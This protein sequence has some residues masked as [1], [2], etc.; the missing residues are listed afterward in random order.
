MNPQGGGGSPPPGVDYALKSR[1]IPNQVMWPLTFVSRDICTFGSGDP[2]HL[3]HVT[4]D[5]L[6]SP[7]LRPNLSHRG[8]EAHLSFHVSRGG[9]ET[10]ELQGPGDTETAH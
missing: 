3:S 5:R 9:G 4:P 6:L 2:S 10:N 1:D 7:W 8:N